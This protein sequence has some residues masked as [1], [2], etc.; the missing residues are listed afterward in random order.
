MLQ[1]TIK[2]VLF[3]KIKQWLDTINDGAVKRAIENDLIVTGGCFASMLQNEAP[4]D[5][6]CY[7]RTKESVLIVAE[8]YAKLW[9]ESHLG[10]ETKIHKHCKVMVLDG[11]KPSEEICCY[12]GADKVAEHATGAVLIDNCPPDRVKMIF[13]SDGYTGD[14]EEVG[15]D[16]ELGTT[17]E[18]VKEL[19]EIEAEKV[20]EEEK[21]PFFPVFI[22]SNAIT[23]SSGIQIVVRFHGEPATIHDSYDYVHTK[24][25]WMYKDGEVVIP[26]EVYDAVVNKTLLYTGSKYPVCS[27]FRL[28][29][30]INRGWHINAGQI[31]KMCMQISELDLTDINVLE[32][33]LI[34]VDS[35]YFMELINQFRHKKEKD[36][37]FEL[38]SGY[39]YSIVDKIF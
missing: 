8:Y 34:G 25:Y 39:V 10:Q 14:P 24:A 6:D 2:Q 23:L 27:V 20:E 32:D 7:F 15:A 11:A 22:S 35:L 12:Y 21:K 17:T 26:N 4:K 1:K 28:R 18:I 9:N 38:T 36:P 29:K 3:K 19:D 5:Y 16:E 13:P 31:L 33:Q 30:F 37:T